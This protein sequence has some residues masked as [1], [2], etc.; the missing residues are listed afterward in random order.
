MAIKSTKCK[1]KILC[2]LCGVYAAYQPAVGGIYDADYR[3][4]NQTERGGGCNTACV[5]KI[6]DKSI[7]LRPREYEILKEGTDDV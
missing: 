2:P 7:C 1:V 5:I 3:M 6:R 4:S